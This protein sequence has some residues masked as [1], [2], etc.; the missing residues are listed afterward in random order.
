M[1]K[2]SAHL[3]LRVGHGIILPSSLLRLLV[4]PLSLAVQRNQHTD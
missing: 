2:C 3:I 4:S 1:S